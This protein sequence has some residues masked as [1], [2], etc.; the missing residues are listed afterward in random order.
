[1]WIWDSVGAGSGRRLVKDLGALQ[2]A[3]CKMCLQE[4][5]STQLAAGPTH[6][7]FISSLS[8]CAPD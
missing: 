2:R 4:G 7:S 8:H 5:E 3:G 6:L 1:M